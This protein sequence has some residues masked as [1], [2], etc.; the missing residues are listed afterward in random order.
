ML[1]GPL[2]AARA[3]IVVVT[4]V[5]VMFGL[6]HWAILGRAQSMVDAMIDRLPS[7][8][9]ASEAALSGREHEVLEVIRRGVLSDHDIGQMLH[10][11]RSTAATHVQNILRKTGLHDRRNLMLL[12]KERS[13]RHRKRG[14]VGA[15]ASGS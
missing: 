5:A 12:R 9:S 1:L 8:A 10:I 14:T 7:D 15:A 13:T 6:R 3:S 11:S 4:T 2:A